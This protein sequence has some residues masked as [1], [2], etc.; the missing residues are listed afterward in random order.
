MMELHRIGRRGFLKAS[1]RLAVA[2]A[3]WQVNLRARQEETAQA[4]LTWVDGREL[5]VEGRGWLADERLRYFDRFPAKAEGVVRDEVWNLSRDSAGMLVRFESDSPE[6][7]VRY[8]LFKERLAMSHMPATGVS[9]VDLYGLDSENR[10]RWIAVA[11]PT[12]Q[13]VETRLVSDLEAGSRNYML[14]LPLYNGINSIEVGVL[15]G[16]TI[17]ALPSRKQR[18]TLFYGTS[19]THGACASRPGI[20][21]PAIL[22]RRLDR[23]VINL[24]FSGNGRME[25]EVGALLAE[26]DPAVYVI[27]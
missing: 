5:D 27:D 18:P 13:K 12:E 26:L 22:G 23:P 16:H 24:G 10:W 7:H 4:A 6:I 19:I 14:Y 11:R 17:K 15:E 3:G 20:P 25:P 9:G 8:E 21:H 2:F 1:S